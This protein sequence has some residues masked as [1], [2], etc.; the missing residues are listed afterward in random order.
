MMSRRG[1]GAEGGFGA[2]RSHP[3]L[4]DPAHVSFS[5]GAVCID[6]LRDLVLAVPGL[7]PYYLCIFCTASSHATAG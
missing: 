6:N 5:V 3:D 4:C 7:D 1:S 2:T